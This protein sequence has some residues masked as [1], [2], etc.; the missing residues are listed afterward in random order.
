MVRSFV[1]RILLMCSLLNAVVIGAFAGDQDVALMA[2]RVLFLGDSITHSGYYISLI[3]LELLR[4]SPDSI[5]EIINLGLPSET[6]SGLSEPGHPFPRPNVHERLERALEKL[7][8]DV[9]VACYG[10]NDGVYHPF[11]E[12]RFQIFQAGINSLI[13]KVHQ[14][15]A[16]LILLTPPPFD[17]LP[18][19][20]KGKLVPAD[21]DEFAYYSI[22]DNYDDV[23]KRYAD[24]ILAQKDRVEMVIDLHS[25][26]TNFVS[27]KRESDP[28]FVLSGDGVHLNHEG[29]RILAEAILNAWGVTPSGENDPS[30]EKLVHQRQMLWHAAYLSDVGHVR[31]GMNAGPPLDEAEV[32]ANALTEQI[33]DQLD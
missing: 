6:A 29:H 10:M 19:K 28:E 22:Y 27:Q 5:P 15:G 8:P 21:A 25:P 7:K 30:L 11:D 3:E 14:S 13:E 1:F 33:E 17:P 23:I 24:W 2:E 9:V 18:L 12:E 26:V 16:K 31:P 4:Q 20:M 32:K